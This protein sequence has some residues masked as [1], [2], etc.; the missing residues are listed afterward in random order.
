M[1]FIVPSVAASA[2]TMLALGGDKILMGPLSTLSPID[3]SLTNH[4]L[5]PKDSDNYPV[6]IE[7]TQIQKFIELLNVY[8]LGF[9]K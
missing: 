9:L 2:C 6:R 3:I 4:E 5:A 8:F 7:V 1:E